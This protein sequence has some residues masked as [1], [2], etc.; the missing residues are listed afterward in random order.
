MVYTMKEVEIW[1]IICFLISL[2][3][4]DKNWR[5]ECP[6]Q[7]AFISCIIQSDNNQM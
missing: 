1:E 7:Y 5:S 2:K 4:E 6:S 3:Y